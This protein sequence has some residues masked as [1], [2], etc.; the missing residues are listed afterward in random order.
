[1]CNKI[2][3]LDISNI[4]YLHDTINREHAWKTKWQNRYE[5]VRVLKE[6]RQRYPD[7]RLLLLWDS[8]RWHIGSKVVEW[9]KQDG[10]IETLPFPRYSPAENPQEHVWKSGRREVKHNRFIA[11]IDRATNDFVRY[12]NRTTLPYRLL[13]FSDIS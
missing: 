3:F 7:Q 1:M 2:Q 6:L 8:T 10:Q 13:G 5:T 11:N 12:L 9:M 4:P